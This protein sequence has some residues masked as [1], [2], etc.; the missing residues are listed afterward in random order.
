MHFPNNEK[1]NF[2]FNR[3]CPEG[4][5]TSYAPTGMYKTG[6]LAIGKK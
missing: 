3:L 4:V 6:H 2:A 5:D 1:P